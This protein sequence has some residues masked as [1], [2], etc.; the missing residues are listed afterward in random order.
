MGQRFD[1]NQASTVGL[2]RQDIEVNLTHA[3]DWVAYAPGQETAEAMAEVA[4]KVHREG[5]DRKFLEQ[6]AAEA[7]AP[8]TLVVQPAGGARKAVARTQVEEAREDK[9]THVEE[10]AKK[11]NAEMISSGEKRLTFSMWDCGGQ[12][13]FYNLIHLFFSRCSVYLIV[14][15]M[16]EILSE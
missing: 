4:A 12:K 9:H 16:H 1:A 2:A 11:L 10:V 15:D 3:R 13:V 14:F 8:S 7:D 6:A 5:A